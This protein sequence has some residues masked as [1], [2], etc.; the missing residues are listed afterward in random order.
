MRY[1]PISQTSYSM[2]KLLLVI[3]MTVTACLSCS[4]EP[5]TAVHNDARDRLAKH[6]AHTDHS[7]F[8]HKPFADGPASSVT[9]I[10]HKRL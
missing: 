5:D 1:L 7:S 9:R 4:S 8:F 6:A 2:R 10:Q 3:L